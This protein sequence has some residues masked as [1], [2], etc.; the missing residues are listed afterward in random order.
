MHADIIA[1]DRNARNG[2]NCRVG[3]KR[4]FER[5]FVPRLA[6]KVR[7]TVGTK[8]QNGKLLAPLEDIVSKVMD[9]SS[10]ES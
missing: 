9:S 3:R 8:E 6:D 2:R 10:K 7:I 5:A 1:L 4:R